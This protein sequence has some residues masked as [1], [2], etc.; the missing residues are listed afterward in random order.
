M[1]D[2]LGVQADLQNVGHLIKPTVIVLWHNAHVCL[3]SNKIECSCS[4]LEAHRCGIGSAFY[5]L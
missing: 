5:L 2:E 3:L 1:V 4:P